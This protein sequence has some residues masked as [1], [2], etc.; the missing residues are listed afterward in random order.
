MPT[1]AIILIISD[2][3]D[4]FRLLVNIAVVAT[5]VDAIP[6][7]IGEVSAVSNSIFYFLTI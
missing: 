4:G 1:Y 3:I 5:R 6:A 7:Y 2:F